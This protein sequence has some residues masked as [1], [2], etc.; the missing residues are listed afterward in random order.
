MSQYTTR[1]LFSGVD[2]TRAEEFRENDEQVE[3]QEEQIAHE[4]NVITRANL[5]KTA[6]QGSFGLEFRN[7]PPTGRPLETEARTV[8]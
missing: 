5:R 1:L 2:A 3:R 4:S 6:P 8:A 7:S